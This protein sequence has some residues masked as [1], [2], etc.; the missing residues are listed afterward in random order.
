MVALVTNTFG[1]CLCLNGEL[2]IRAH[3]DRAADM[4]RIDVFSEGVSGRSALLGRYDHDARV[5]APPRVLA[6]LVRYWRERQSFE[7]RESRGCPFF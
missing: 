5:L 7:H 4:A 6:H 3:W 2:R 1:G